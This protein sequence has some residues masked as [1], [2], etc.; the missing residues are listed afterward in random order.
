MGLSDEEKF[1]INTIAY[2]SIIDELEKS[3]TFRKEIFNDMYENFSKKQK[4]I[5]NTYELFKNDHITG[6]H[7]T[8]KKMQKK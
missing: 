6:L 2:Y 5:V 4:A 3:G 8:W 1:I 7:K